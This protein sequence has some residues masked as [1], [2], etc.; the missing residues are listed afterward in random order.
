MSITAPGKLVR[1]AKGG[2]HIETD[3]HSTIC[4]HQ[5]ELSN[6]HIH[7]EIGKQ[8]NTNS[9]D[10]KDISLQAQHS[11]QDISG[12]HRLSTYTEQAPQPGQK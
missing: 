3:N 12:Q 2:W 1:P 7:K 8:Q 4:K 5:Y 9:Y 10:T 6:S 11:N